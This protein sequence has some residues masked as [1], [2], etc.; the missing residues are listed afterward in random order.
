[1][2]AALWPPSTNSRL[3]ALD[4]RLGP[5]H[6]AHPLLEDVLAEALAAAAT[7]ITTPP[8]RTAPL[9]LSSVFCAW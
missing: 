2:A 1:M 5:L 6:A 3:D 7:R 9:T 4:E 8:S